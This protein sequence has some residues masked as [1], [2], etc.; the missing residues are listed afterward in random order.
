MGKPL[1][2]FCWLQ[3]PLPPFLD[4]M[5]PNARG[6]SPASRFPP[7]LSRAVPIRWPVGLYANVASVQ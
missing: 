3:D 1:I 6:Q 5:P 4:T 7:S 2:P